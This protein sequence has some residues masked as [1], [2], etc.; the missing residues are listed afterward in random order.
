MW[1][2]EINFAQ[3]LISHLEKSRASGNRIN[4]GLGSTFLLTF[5]LRVIMINLMASEQNIF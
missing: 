3:V 4:L 5:L 2:C 1:D